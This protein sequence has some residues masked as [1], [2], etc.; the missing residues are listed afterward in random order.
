MSRSPPGSKLTRKVSPASKRLGL[1]TM[2]S[3]SRMKVR[4]PDLRRQMSPACMSSRRRSVLRWTD[5]RIRSRCR[6]RAKYRPPGS[7]I[8]SRGP[9]HTS[10]GKK[11]WEVAGRRGW[12]LRKG[13]FVLGVVV[14]NFRFAS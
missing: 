10:P 6:R 13:V 9:T 14:C 4:K 5:S 3:A 2:S 7:G 11:D 1:W 12:R 8:R